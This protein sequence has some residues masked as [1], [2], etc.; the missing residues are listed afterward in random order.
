MASRIRSV[1]AFLASADPARL[2]AWYRA[3]G[4]ELGEEGHTAIGG[5]TPADGSVFSIMP[6]SAPLAAPPEGVV[7]EEPYGLR[8]ITLNFHVE[9]LDG[10]VAGLRQR[11]ETVAGPRDY[12]YGRF[13]W[14]HDPD[15]N[16]VELWEAADAP[17]P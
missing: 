17:P 3:L 4:I 9:N 6:A 5:T 11:G 1:G 7:E 15:G 12:G 13:A 16:V 10:V 14:V 2:V 8:A